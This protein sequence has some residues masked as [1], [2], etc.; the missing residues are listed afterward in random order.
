MSFNQNMT[1]VGLNSIDTA[2]PTAGSYFVKGK[3]TLPRL[4]SG[5]G[6][7]G[8][9]GTSA[10]VVTV[11]NQTGPVTVY[12]GIAGAQG[13]YTNAVCAAGDVLRVA[14]TSADTD[15]QGLNTVKCSISIGSGQ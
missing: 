4:S 7:T 14:L 13:F 2:V 1:L 15:D 6:T 11:T 8:G 9:D 12:T 10:V 3:L 5:I